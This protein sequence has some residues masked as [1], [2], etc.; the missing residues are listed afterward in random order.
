MSF[1]LRASPGRAAWN[2]LYGAARF[3][4]YPGKKHD[5]SDLTS[6]P[7]RGVRIMHYN[8]YHLPYRLS[9]R[10]FTPRSTKA[11]LPAQ[12]INRMVRST[13]FALGGVLVNRGS[14]QPGRCVGPALNGN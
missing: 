14:R 5:L 12:D 11:N 7:L 6:R 4:A 3:Y 10:E 8:C 2:Y 9:T 1:H 13:G